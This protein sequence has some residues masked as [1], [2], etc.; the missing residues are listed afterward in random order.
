MTKVEYT[1]IHHIYN[2]KE[3]MERLQHVDII[4]F[5]SSYLGLFTDAS[6]ILLA[7]HSLTSHQTEGITL[8]AKSK[9]ITSRLD[10]PRST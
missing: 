10:F 1:Y 5:C 3:E 7:V 4:K 8:Y 2:G 6:A 9:V